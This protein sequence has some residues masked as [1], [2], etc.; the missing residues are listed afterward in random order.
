MVVIGNGSKNAWF[1]QPY[2][3]PGASLR[4]FCFPYAGGNATFYR[5]WQA[6]L[7]SFVEV[8][9]AQLPGRMPR[10]AETPFTEL[11]GMVAAIAENMHPYLDKPFALFGHSM[12]AMI[13]LELARLI[14]KEHQLEPVH[15]FV[16][17]HRAPQIPETARSTYNLPE[18]EFLEE[19][20]QLNGTPQEVLEHPELMQLLAPILRADFSVCQTYHYEPGPPLRCPITAFGGLEDTGER[21]EFL[22]PWKEQTVSA[23]MLKLFPGDHFFIY[24]AQQEILQIIGQQLHQ[25]AMKAH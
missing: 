23:F 1:T 20:R 18:P 22:E 5:T 7:P 3:N 6:S 9:A 8:C 19:L 11:T 17:G 13:S 4:L 14:R 15:L 24:G 21:K 25:S 16:S 12:G 2:M 10:L